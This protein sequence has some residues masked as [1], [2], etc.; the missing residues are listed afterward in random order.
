MTVLPLFPLQTVLFPG[1]RLNLKVFEARYLD[2]VG[3]CLRQG[4]PF[5][6]VC[7]QSGGEVRRKDGGGSGAVRFHDTGVQ[8]HID[9]VDAEQAGILHIRC[10]GRERFELT[11]PRQ[12]PDG[13][14]LADAEL[15]P[16]DTPAT[17]PESTAATVQ[18]LRDAIE[19]MRR[20][21][22]EPFIPPYQFNDAGWVANRWC[23]I[24]PIS[25][26]AKQKLMA[27]DDPVAR[28]KLVDEF[29]RDQGVVGS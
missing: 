10:S 15:L 1:G 11:Q 25:R 24:L 21:G 5:G 29:L 7:L 3:D 16:A 19:A 6:V 27:L 20:E 22:A 23:E 8:A 13:L 14:W 17:P 26:P 9:E 2:M 4:R 18:A 28:L 12:Q